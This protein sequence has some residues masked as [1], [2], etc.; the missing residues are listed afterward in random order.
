M[1][2]ME[3]IQSQK[4]KGHRNLS[5]QRPRRRN[6]L[7]KIKLIEFFL[8]FLGIDR[9]FSRNDLK[10]FIQNYNSCN[11]YQKFNDLKQKYQFLEGYN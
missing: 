7:T 10:S 5:K 3:R 6:Q 4:Y 8:N 11:N 9:L 1:K 2:K